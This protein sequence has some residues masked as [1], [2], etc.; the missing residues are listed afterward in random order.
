MGGVHAYLPFYSAS[1]IKRGNLF[2]P[3]GKS[4]VLGITGREF[5]GLLLA[6]YQ[7]ENGHPSLG[8]AMVCK[9]KPQADRLDFS[10]YENAVKLVETSK[11]RQTV[12]DMAK[13]AGIGIV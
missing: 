6:G 5:F 2:R 13:D 4:S 3:E 10:T 8:I 11:S 9:N 1:E 7:A 12:I